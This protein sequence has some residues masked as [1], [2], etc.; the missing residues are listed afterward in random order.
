MRFNRTFPMPGIRKVDVKVHYYP[1]EDAVA[2]QYR[3]D[4]INYY[5]FW[6]HNGREVF[7]KALEAYKADY[8]ER[9]LDRRDRQSRR[10]YGTANGY[11]MWFTHAFSVRAFSGTDLELGYL[12][13]DGSPYFTVNQK[14]VEHY[15]DHLNESRTLQIM[16]TYFTRAQADELAALFDEDFLEAV[17]PAR[18][19]PNSTTVDVDE[20]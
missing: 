11:I 12:F 20:Y 7:R 15:D 14:P 9:N 19:V 3:M 18:S 1:L 4:M 17:I 8:E 16:T 2:L 6:S 10:K 5:Q 13:E